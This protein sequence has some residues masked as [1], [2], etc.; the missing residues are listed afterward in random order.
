[1]RRV[2]L[3]ALFVC[4]C[5][6]YSGP[7]STAAPPSASPSYSAQS[8][9]R[10]YPVSVG[11]ASGGAQSLQP[12]LSVAPSTPSYSLQGGVD[13]GGG[14]EARREAAIT[15]WEAQLQRGRDELAATATQCRVICMAAS[16]V[17]TATRE[18][19]RLTGDLIAGVARDPRC[20]R[21]R[22]ACVDAGRRR[23]GA[24]PVCPER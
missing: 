12:G 6:S 1:M 18:I 23:D 20:A 5:A 13:D 8:T 9:A 10:E 7:R 17:C 21:A 2:G 16:N 4:G 24:C 11:G 3:A 15:R 14:D 19:C 22:S